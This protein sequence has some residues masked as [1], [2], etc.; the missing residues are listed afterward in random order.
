MSDPSGATSKLTQDQQDAIRQAVSV[1]RERM[2]VEPVRLPKRIEQISVRWLRDAPF[3][4][5]FLL[6]FYYFYTKGIPT[7]GVSCVKGRINLYINEEFMNGGGERIKFEN[8]QP[9]IKKDKAGNPELDDKG[10]LQYETVPWKGLKEAELEG[11]LV[12][13]I[14]HL[15]R[16]HYERC[17]E[18]HYLWNIAGDMLINHSIKDTTIGGVKIELPEGGVF[19]DLARK[20]GYEGEEVTE[21]LYYWLVEKREE[22]QK[23]YG[24]CQTCGGS[25][26]QDCDQCGGSGQKDCH[27]CGGKGEKQGEGGGKEQ[28]QGQGQEQDQRQGQGQDQGGGHQHG[29]GEPCS[30]GGSGQE[31]C[32]KCGGKGEQPCPDCGG[33]GMQGGDL[34]DA[35]FGSKIDVHDIMDAESDG[36]SEET[37]KEIVETAKMKGWGTISGNMV[38]MLKELTRPSVVGWK[39]LLRRALASFTYGYGTAVENTWSKRN[40][41]TKYLPGMRK[42]NNRAVIGVDTS[43][44]IGTEELQQFFT[45]IEA[46]VREVS[47]LTVVLWDTEIKGVWPEYKKGDWQKIEIAGRGGTSTQLVFDWMVEN[48]HENDMLIMLTDGD[49]SYDYDTH[50]VETLWCVTVPNNEPPGGEVIHVD[51]QD[52]MAGRR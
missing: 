14:E 45:E 8:N 29:D 47:M 40:R 28:G 32:D 6:R 25:G 3:F 9:V 12:H 35:M 36:L 37:V 19:L 23:K 39:Q 2:K 22:F 4:S 50:G 33:S 31:K 48:K 15:I 46:I 51:M 13:E 24:K 52:A 1:I 7:M 34:F 26:K 41:R 20:E 18:D 5:E 16:L 44:S 49:F 42:L 21:P 30:C 43:G 10:R 38:E 11:V 17:L 27:E